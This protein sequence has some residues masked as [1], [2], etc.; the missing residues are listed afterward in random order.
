MAFSLG[1]F[2]GGMAQT[3]MN[4]YQMLEAIES[5]KKRDALIE[6][7]M[8]E[9]KQ[10]MADRA[11]I[12]GLGKET[13]GKIGQDDLT[14]PLTATTGIG[15]QQAGML[16]SGSGDVNFDAYDRQQQAAALRGNVEYQNRPDVQ[17]RLSAGAAAGL[18]TTQEQRTALAPAVG[19]YTEEQAAKDY[20]TR[21]KG[22][23][24]EKGLAAEK[25]LMD[26]KKGGLEIGGLERSER[27]A[28]QQEVALGFQQQVLKDL[29][30][31]KGDIGSVL[32]KHFLPLYNENK[33]PGLNDGK[34]AKVLPSATKG[35]EKTI[36][37]TDKNGKQTTMP[38]NIET[39]QMLTSQAQDLMMASSS[40]ENYWKHKANFLDER[41]TKAT[42][43][44]AD[45]AV[46]S[47]KAAVMNAKTNQQA[48]GAKS[49]YYRALAKKAGM[50]LTAQ[51]LEEID[52]Q[53]AIMM[54]ADP[55]LTKE[56][57][58]LKSAQIIF[59]SPELRADVVT[60][61]QINTF[62]QNNPDLMQ[63]KG[64]SGKMEPLNEIERADVARR[65]LTRG[66][67]GAG[68]PTNATDAAI[69]ALSNNTPGADP[70]APKSAEPPGAVDTTKVPTPSAAIPTS[71]PARYN[72]IDPA[73]QDKMYAN[74]TAL[75]QQI[76]KAEAV[77]RATPNLANAQ[78]LQQL[79]AERDKLAANPLLR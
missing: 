61:D 42:E 36:V 24:F 78:N 14:G 54:R 62:I 38:A 26:I 23:D 1:A 66:S 9:A 75:D 40:P 27:F 10:N 69:K 33:L 71:G 47:A 79:R 43:K 57:A 8:Q 11:A 46:E 35:G 7:Q 45:A 39:L 77:L 20:A 48:E 41:K 76:Q 51:K 44:Q 3:G 49:D 12:K 21:L 22:I 64:K 72:N 63:K 68:A 65:A 58:D 32:E 4:T 50:S 17:E 6:L 60:P 2:A 13:Y 31:A 5:Q 34:S 37:I 59:K 25:G 67:S 15:Q 19:K 30:A 70:F 73:L 74:V 56:Q 28:K 18:P 53:S 29:A 52:A 55:K 16:A